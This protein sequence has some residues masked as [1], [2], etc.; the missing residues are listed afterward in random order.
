MSYEVWGDGPD[1]YECKSCDELMTQRDDNEEAAEKLADLIADL[2]DI[3]IG[4]HSSGNDPWQN[5]I[6]AAEYELDKRKRA[7][8]I[9]RGVD[10]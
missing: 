8:L 4:E 2:L 3:D 5:A 9:E 7:S 10:P 6:D 1:D